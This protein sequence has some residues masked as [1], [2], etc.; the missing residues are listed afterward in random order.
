MRAFIFIFAM[1]CVTIFFV[2]GKQGD[3]S[4][5]PPIE[6][7]DDM[8]RQAKFRPQ[9]PNGFFANGRT[10]Q[11][12]V[13]GTVARGTSY[14]DIPENTGKPAGQGHNT[15]F[16]AVIPVSI[17]VTEEFIKRGQERYQIS[18]QVCHGTI[19]DGNGIT[20]QLGMAV[21]A[22]LHDPRIVNLGDGEIFNTITHGKNLMGGY[23]AN[24][25]INDRW[26]IVAYVRALQRSQLGVKA[27]VPKSLWDSL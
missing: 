25:S 11:R 26:A 24:I 8:V 22:N 2:A 7:F 4:R 20:K 23:G 27:E 3:D 5:K 19:G 9:Q 12:F 14:Q 18:C 17:K 10:S 21:V 1:V 16:V 15:N 13:E 6:I